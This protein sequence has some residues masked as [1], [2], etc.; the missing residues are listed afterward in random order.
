VRNNSQFFFLVWASTYIVRS[1]LSM[2]ASEQQVHRDG[3]PFA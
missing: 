3:L 2:D 1:M